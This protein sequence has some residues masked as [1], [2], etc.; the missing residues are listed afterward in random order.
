MT[1]SWPAAPCLGLMLLGTGCAG[2]TKAEA[3]PQAR[4]L[5]HIIATADGFAIRSVAQRPG[6]VPGL[7]VVPVGNS[8]RL[9][10]SLLDSSNRPDFEEI[11]RCP[12]RQE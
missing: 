12:H 5:S 1:H 7:R 8:V 11:F 3:P 9:D 2:A 10:R 6:L 4:P